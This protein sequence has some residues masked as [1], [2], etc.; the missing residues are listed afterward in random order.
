MIWKFINHFNTMKKRQI[1]SD[2]VES[3]LKA[4]ILNRCPLCGRFE[5]TEKP[6]TNHHINHDSSISEYFNLIR[7]CVNCHNDLTN[8]KEDTKRTRK[9]RQVKKDLFRNLIG[10]AS[11]EVLLLAFHY[12]V[13]SSLP[14]L[15]QQLLKLDLIAIKQDN[16]FKVGLANHPTITDYT[17]TEMGTK[18]VNDLNLK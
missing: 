16:P 1:I 18:L 14:C 12:D 5:L 10:S 6:F 15:A 3:I 9:V 13:T 17:I 7:I 8:H 4:E 11:Y 2:Y